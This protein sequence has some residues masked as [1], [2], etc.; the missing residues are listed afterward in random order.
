MKAE[1]NSIKHGARI[2]SAAPYL[3]VNDTQIEGHEHGSWFATCEKSK[4]D[5]LLGVC[6][7]SWSGRA[8]YSRLKL[9]A[10]SRHNLVEILRIAHQAGDTNRSI[11]ELPDHDELDAAKLGGKPLAGLRIGAS[12]EKGRHAIQLSYEDALIE[13]KRFSGPLTFDG[14]F[15]ESSTG[16]ENIRGGE[17]SANDSAKDNR[18][19]SD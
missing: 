11:I 16:Q 17:P 14:E 3:S 15:V 13:Y 18:A 6:A 8:L 1:F 7:R 5:I 19:L 12:W 9:M 10:T 2:Q 4:S